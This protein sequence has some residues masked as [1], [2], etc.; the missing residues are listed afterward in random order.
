[1][2]PRLTTELS[3]ERN[4][5]IYQLCKCDLLAIKKDRPVTTPNTFENEILI[6]PQRLQMCH[7]VGADCFVKSIVVWYH[8]SSNNRGF[9]P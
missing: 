9:S 2:K 6:Y 3:T 8:M 7:F 4:V 5:I 1:M